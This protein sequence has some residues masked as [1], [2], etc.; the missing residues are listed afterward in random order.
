M[1]RPF[2]A[3]PVEVDE[4]ALAPPAPGPAGGV[5][6]RPAAGVPQLGARND[7]QVGG[8]GVGAGEH[9]VGLPVQAARRS[10]RRALSPARA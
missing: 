10:R 1:A 7:Q 4:L 8:A 3:P 6:L 9:R 2:E 5:S